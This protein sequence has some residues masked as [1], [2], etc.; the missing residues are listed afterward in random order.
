MVAARMND[1]FP[2]T[3][4]DVP[5]P[6]SGAPR[7]T[8]M[9]QPETVNRTFISVQKASTHLYPPH[10]LGKS[11]NR[12]LNFQQVVFAFPVSSRTKCI[13]FSLSVGTRT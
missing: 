4:P 13:P 9:L 7:R 2:D 3:V 6:T 12:K 1:D 8:L 5:R 11:I 10:N